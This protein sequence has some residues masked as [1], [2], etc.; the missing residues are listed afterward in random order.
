[1]V[2]CESRQGGLACLWKKE[3]DSETLCF[4][5]SLINV[6]VKSNALNEMALYWGL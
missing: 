4:S 6:R 1:M 5:S 3:V 2:D